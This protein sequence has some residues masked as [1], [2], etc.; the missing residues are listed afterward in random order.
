MLLKR[1]TSQIPE[2]LR[3]LL[4]QL[5]AAGIK[6]TENL[7][8]THPSVLRGL[9]PDQEVSLEELHGICLALT[10]PPELLALHAA[11]RLLRAEPTAQC[12]WLDADG[13][14]HPTRTR[15]ILDAMGENDPT[16]VL[17]RLIV[18]PCFRIDPELYD[19]LAA[20]K[21]EYERDEDHDA[22]SVTRTRMLVI[23][24]LSSLLKD[25]LLA[26]TAQ[27]HAAMVTVLEEI[28]ELTYSCGLATIIINFPSS[29]L[30]NN[31]H[32]SFSMTTIRPAL[33]TAF[34]YFADMTLLVQ[35]TGKLFGQVDEE[36]RERVRKQPGLRAVVEVLKSRVS[37][38][39]RWAVFETD[40]TSLSGVVP[41]RLDD[42]RTIR[43]SAGLPVGLQRPIH[44]PLARTVIP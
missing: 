12:R 10:A 29:S 7:L 40:G 26:S 33:G 3:P 30:P 35:E 31:A 19:G 28:S 15:A 24:P 8:F 36:E 5:D 27:G 17:D 14:F 37:P 20:I 18:S 22:G 34:T 21:A 9:L 2:H 4:P 39:G 38:S 1:L 42:E 32:S 23:D 43:M 13:S 11:L 6:T 16:S 41:P 44:G 25:M